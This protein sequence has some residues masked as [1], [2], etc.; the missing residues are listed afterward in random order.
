[1]NPTQIQRSGPRL[2]IF[3]L[4]GTLIDSSLDLC[5]S[6]NAALRQVG[7]PELPHDRIAGFIGDGAAT[8]VRRALADAQPRKQPEVPEAVD[9]ELLFQRSFQHFLSFYREHKLDHTR[10]YA[11]VL[12]AL[13]RLRQVFPGVR[14]AVLTNKPVRPAVEICR[15]LEIAPFFSRIY[16]GDSFHSKKPDPVGVY[17]LFRDAD[18]VSSAMGGVPSADARSAAVMIG[19]SPIDVLTARHAGIRSL[20]CRYGLDPLAMEQ[21]GPDLLC[22]TPDQW[23]EL[24]S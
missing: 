16:G 22:D 12:P 8:L 18:L 6:V 11:G 1:M 21:A 5:L 2:L 15:G 3:D 13:E 17:Q 23:P 19:D 4:D 9:Q 20:G 24:L 10:L 7:I 14:M